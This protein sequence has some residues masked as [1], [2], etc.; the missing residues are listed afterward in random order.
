MLHALLNDGRTRPRLG[1]G[2]GRV[3]DDQTRTAVADAL[4][5][6][7][8]AIDTA[9]RYGNETGVGRAVAASGIARSDLYV[10][11]K[12]W[13]DEQGYDRT[14]RAF[15]ASLD[16]LGLDYADSYLIHWPA[17]ELNAYLDTWRALVRLRSEG[18]VHSIGVCNFTEPLLERLVQE[19]GEVPAVNQIE[20]HPYLSRMELRGA[21]ARHGVLTEAWS[22]LGQGRGMLADPV[23]RTVADKHGRSPA[24][25]VLRWHLQLG[26]AVIPKSVTPS[27][28]R[29]NI[30]VFDF[31]LD[32]EDLTAIAAL[33]RDEHCGQDPATYR[34]AF[35]TG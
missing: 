30:D 2:V 19:S 4:R 15:D 9:S 13:N 32:A 3:A 1:L 5:A 27:R 31:V 12:V 6:G 21:N 16:R 34:R 22:P 7:Y 28:I 25:V 26:N 20:L 29:E 23:L 8:R 10:T 17:P 11:T 18:R 33:N 14:L 35:T 24:Q